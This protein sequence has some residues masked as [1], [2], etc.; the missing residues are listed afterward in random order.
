MLVAPGTGQPRLLIQVYP[1]GQSLDK[2]LPDRPWKANPAT[3]M[4]ELLRQTGVRLGLVTNGEAW[5]LVMRQVERD[6]QLHH[7]VR[8]PVGR[9]AADAARVPQPVGRPALL[10]RAR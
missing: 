7:L 9:G 4:M 3:R 10:R 6:D 8:G 2:T 1:A 5:L